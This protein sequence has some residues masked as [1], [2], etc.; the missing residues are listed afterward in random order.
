MHS[1]A[2]VSMDKLHAKNPLFYFFILAYT[3]IAL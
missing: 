3:K 2:A 1:Q